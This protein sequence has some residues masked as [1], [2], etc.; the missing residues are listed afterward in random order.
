MHYSDIASKLDQ[1][2]LSEALLRGFRTPAEIQ[3]LGTVWELQLGPFAGRRYIG[4]YYPSGDGDVRFVE[5]EGKISFLPINPFRLDV[6]RAT[7]LGLEEKIFKQLVDVARGGPRLASEISRPDEITPFYS[8]ISSLKDGSI[9]GPLD[10]FN[11]VEQVR[12]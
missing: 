4:G 2:I 10:F 1:P 6:G 7:F 12:L 8:A 11:P 5:H 3:F 9:L